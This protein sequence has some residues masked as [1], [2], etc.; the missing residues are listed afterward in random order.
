MA[1]SR[2]ESNF[3]KRPTLQ[4][5][6]VETVFNGNAGWARRT[7]REMAKEISGKSLEFIFV[8][9]F[10]T[11]AIGELFGRDYSNRWYGLIVLILIAFLVKSYLD[12]FKNDDIIKEVNPPNKKS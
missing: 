2:G 11:T 10:I 12:S 5:Q 6:A 4:K 1:I 3:E 7:L 9:S 8:F